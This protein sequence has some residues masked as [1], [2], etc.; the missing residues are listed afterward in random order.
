MKG[1]FSYD[2]SAN[3]STSRNKVVDLAG[4]DEIIGNYN[5]PIINTVTRVGD[6]INSY[7]CYK[8]N[9]IIQTQ[10]DLDEYKE[11]LYAT[12]PAEITARTW[13]YMADGC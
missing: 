3:F 6:P 5:P 7:F 13:R 9:G 10:D 2:I 4:L 12:D 8:T 11:M 1:A